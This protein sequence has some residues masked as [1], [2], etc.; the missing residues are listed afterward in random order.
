MT[1]SFVIV[2][3]SEKDTKAQRSNGG[4]S[5]TAHRVPTFEY[6]ASGAG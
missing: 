2:A 1:S 3:G 5:E 6:G 4:G